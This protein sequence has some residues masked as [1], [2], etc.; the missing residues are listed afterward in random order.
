MADLLVGITVFP[1]Y[2]ATGTRHA[3]IGAA[4]AFLL[5]IADAFLQV[6]LSALHGAGRA[7]RDADPVIAACAG[8]CAFDS[9]G[10]LEMCIGQHRGTIG[11]PAAPLAIDTDHERAWMMPAGEL[12]EALQADGTGAGIKDVVAVVRLACCEP[13]P[14]GV[15][16]EVVDGVG[17][18]DAGS[19][20]ALPE[21]PAGVAD[22]DELAAGH[23]GIAVLAQGG[24]GFRREV[25]DIEYGL[26]EE[27]GVV[28]QGGVEGLNGVHGSRLVAV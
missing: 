1:A 12:A 23:S 13:L 27:A 3:G 22:Q 7:A 17:R 10:R 18:V 5:A 26:K 6:E 2:G 21:F 25:V 14:Y 4:R 16:G 11:V 20:H 8:R 19:L 28:E 9:P 24:G 15:D